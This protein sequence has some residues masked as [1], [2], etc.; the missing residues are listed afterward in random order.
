M[1]AEATGP[2]PD[3]PK[4]SVDGSEGG[5]VTFH[6]VGAPP[7]GPTSIALQK[8]FTSNTQLCPPPVRGSP[9]LL[10]SKTE[11]SG[12]KTEPSPLRPGDQM[13]TGGDPAT[14]PP[15]GNVEPSAHTAQAKL[16]QRNVNA[17]A[18]ATTR[19][20]RLPGTAR[21]FSCVIYASSKAFLDATSVRT[22]G[23]NTIGLRYGT[24]VPLLV[25]LVSSPQS[26]N[27][28]L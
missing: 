5:N 2:G 25:P 6:A 4:H 8:V 7:A 13:V 21:H 19:R 1:V 23:A 18:V 16:W 22:S 3:R 20:T 28:V 11:I 12:T 17:V 24:L 15:A 26:C 27:V 9:G 10:C 14:K